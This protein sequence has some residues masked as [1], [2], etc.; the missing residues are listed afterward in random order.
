MSMGELSLLPLGISELNTTNPIHVIDSS[1][2][3]ILAEQPQEMIWLRSL[4][5]YNAQ[6]HDA[7][8]IKIKYSQFLDSIVH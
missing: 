4:T 8:Y 7:D 2:P 1:A 3:N 5:S 6:R